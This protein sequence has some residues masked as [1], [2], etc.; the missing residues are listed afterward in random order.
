MVE[1]QGRRVVLRDPRPKDVEARL[2]WSTVETEWQDWDAPWESEGRAITAPDGLDRARSRL[3]AEIGEPLPTPRTR[4][5]IERIG[6][7]LL[8]WVNHYHHDPAARVTY[9]G[10]SI[11]ESGFW[12][13]GLGTEALLLWI[14]YLVKQFDLACVRTAT[15]S[16][17]RRMVRCADKCGFTLDEVEPGVREVRGERYDALAFRLRRREWA[18]SRHSEDESG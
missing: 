4:L 7:P 14:D 11:C 12:N 16:G 6:G 3:L 13:Q 2:R 15:W 5:W 1:V 9:V 18:T 10:I 8:G 17:N